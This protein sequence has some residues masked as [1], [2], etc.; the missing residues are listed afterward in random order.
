M[1]IQTLLTISHISPTPYAFKAFE[2][3]LQP[4][5][6]TYCVISNQASNLCSPPLPHLHNQISHSSSLVSPPAPTTHPSLADTRTH[7]LLK[8]LKSY[9]PLQHGGQR[10]AS[11]SP[12]CHLD[13]APRCI[14]CTISLL[15]R[16]IEFI[17]LPPYT[18]IPKSLPLKKPG[19]I[20]KNV[21]RYHTVT[22][23]HQKP[24]SRQMRKLLHLPVLRRSISTLHRVP[25]W[26]CT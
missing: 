9:F 17:T 7:T 6:N 16:D 21:H 22:L 26:V 8:T 25:P 24:C 3:S 15:R 18:A 4:L 14:A 13:H 2:Y 11:R 23:K 12:E 5:R 10:S 20:H 19:G 1:H